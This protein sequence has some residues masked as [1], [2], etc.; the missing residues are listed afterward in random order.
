MSLSHATEPR[1]RLRIEP[2]PQPSLAWSVAVHGAAVLV[3]LVLTVLLVLMGGADPAKAI[4]A[5]VEGGFGSARAW[6]DTLARATPLIFT[7]LATVV[8]YRAQVWSI[9]QEGQVLAGAMAAFWATS[10]LPGPGAW[11]LVPLILVAGMAGGAAL[12][13]V[14][15]VLKTRFAVSEIIST[16]MMN[17]LIVLLLSWLIGGGPWT[18]VSQ[19]VVYQQSAT[20]PEPAWL[21]ALLGSGKLHLG[22]P[23]ALAAA[24][25]V[26][27]LL[28]RTSLGYEIR[29]LGDNPVALACRGTDVGR[30]ILVILAISGA[31]AGLAGVSEA[32]GTTHRLRADALAG[33]GYTGILIGM[34]GG[35]TPWGTVLAAVVFGG[36]ENGAL[37]MKLVAKVPGALVPTIE[38]VLMLTFL[39]AG[40]AA[41]YRLVARSQDA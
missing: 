6:L 40:V 32:F 19:S 38:G 22:F 26:Q 25:A 39:C 36:L 12:A 5:L 14:T 30:T 9:G 29:A 4:G 16:V 7:G 28:A 23:V 41:R 35:L 2:R 3:A 27:V 10:L 18:E 21:P 17:Y 24:V 1:R 37:Y 8:A 15:A 13:S 20:F 34:I 31:L 33:F 11:P